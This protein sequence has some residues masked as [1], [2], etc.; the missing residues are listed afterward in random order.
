MQPLKGIR[1]LDLTTINPFTDTEFSDYGAEVIKVERPGS[2]DTI[3]DYPPFI[4]GISAYHCYTD[5]GKK[6][7]TLN[8][9]DD[10]GK[11]ILKRL[12]K[13]ADVLVENFK[14]G[15]MEKMGLGFEELSKINPALVYGKLSSYGSV[16]PQKDYI[17]YDIA[18]QAQS[19][20]MDATG[21]PGDEPSRVGCYVSDHLSCTYLGTAIVLALYH[22][23]KT[24]KGQRV[25]VSM[26]DSVVSVMGEKVAALNCGE[27]ASRTGH[28]HDAWAPYDILPCADGWVALAVT[29]DSQWAAFCQAFGKPEWAEV[30][31]TND[32]RRAA[33]L[34]RLRPQ[35][36]ALLAN[37]TR[38]DFDSRCAAAG[39]PAGPVNTMEEAIESDHLKARNMLPTVVDQRVGDVL[40]VGKVIKY[41]GALEDNF[42]T[43]PL[44]G[45]NND[46]IL[47]ACYTQEELAKFQADGVI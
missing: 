41:N 40:T 33:Y 15:T 27:N 20:I 30:Y 32:S 10:Q 36:E 13:D 44:L 4:D 5:R 43:A 45:Q 18:V 31:P 25:E 9:K 6:S 42:T 47:G 22:A 14:N 39:V 7:I 17:A 34:E 2:G 28:L 12:V 1:I 11:E 19:G 3:R 29:E 24:G 8:L 26:L 16:G 37:V 46:E 21:Y 35:L 23:K 38:A